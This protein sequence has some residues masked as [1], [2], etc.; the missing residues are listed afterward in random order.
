MHEVMK[1]IKQRSAICQV[2]TSPLRDTDPNINMLSVA[3]LGFHFGEG[4]RG[5]HI[6]FFGKVWVFAWRNYGLTRMVRKY[7]PLRKLLKNDSF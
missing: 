3:Y 1:E 5:V 7:A 2:I 4:G 6:I